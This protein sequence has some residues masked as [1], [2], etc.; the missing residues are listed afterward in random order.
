MAENREHPDE[1]SGVKIKLTRGQKGSYG[2]EISISEPGSRE[3][4][5]IDRLKFIDERLKAEY[6]EF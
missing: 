6:S 4:S 3:L 2:W 5:I 1:L